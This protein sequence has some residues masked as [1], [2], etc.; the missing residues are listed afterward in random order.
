MKGSNRGIV[1]EKKHNFTAGIVFFVLV[2]L[3]SPSFPAQFLCIFFIFILVCSRLYAEYLSRHIR[4]TRIDSE[5][6]VFRHE[7]VRVEVKVENHGLLPA[8]MLVASDS[9]GDLSVIKMRR[10]FCT[11][12]K[13]SW[14][15]LYWDGLC[16]DRGVFHAGPA[17]IKGSDPLGFYPFRVTSTETTKI[18][19]YPSIRSVNLKNKN[20]IPLGNI[21]SSN[22]LYEDV[23]RYRSLR[24]YYKGDE[25]RRI[26]WK[27]S[28]HV[29]AQ[30]QSGCLLVNE[31]EATASYPV[32]IFLNVSQNEYPAR[33]KKYFT[34]RIIEA[35]AA[36]CLKASRER[37]PFGIII[38]ISEAEGGMS[39]IPASVSSPI[40]ALERLAALD[41]SI[42]APCEP[43][44]DFSVTRNSAGHNSRDPVIARGSVIAML[45]YGRRLSYGTRYIYTGPDLGDEAYITLSLLKKRHLTLEYLIIDE[46][47]LFPAVPGNSPR[48]QVKE[49][50]YDII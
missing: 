16:A 30:S 40:P 25:R 41:Y 9:P 32:M 22:P 34:E 29:S 19:V 47:S 14:T 3:F 10:T 15:R 31:Y 45:N 18:Y 6:R 38:Y 24:L 46:R 5:L 49:S 2:L 7:W 28:A 37:Q 27:A 26:N 35:A 44:K 39:V 48:Y 20:G 4:V 33:N 17:V 8:F 21:T 43:L 1:I 36:F 11:L 13:R 12:F 42:P 23:T 50:G